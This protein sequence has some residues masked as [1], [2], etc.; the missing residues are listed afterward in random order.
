MRS[1]CAAKQRAPRQVAITADPVCQC[2]RDVPPQA[3]RSA[4]P[5]PLMSIATADAFVRG[6]ELPPAGRL[7]EDA[8][9]ASHPP[10]EPSRL[11][12]LC[13]SLT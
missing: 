3:V 6:C 11:L 7:M 4:A 10:W 13:R 9:S 12:V 2:P 1:C 8:G 5:Q